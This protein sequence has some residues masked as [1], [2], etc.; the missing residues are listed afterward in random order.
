[1]RQMIIYVIRLKFVFKYNGR[2]DFRRTGMI[3]SQES[4]FVR[5]ANTVSDGPAKAA[6]KSSQKQPMNP[7]KSSQ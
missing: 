7:A 2:I 5:S 4:Q 6:N 1:M 3:D